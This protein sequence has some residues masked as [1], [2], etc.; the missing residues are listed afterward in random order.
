MKIYLNGNG[1][2]LRLEEMWLVGSKTEDVINIVFLMS[3]TFASKAFLW[4]ACG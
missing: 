4:Y 3:D 1:L 2:V